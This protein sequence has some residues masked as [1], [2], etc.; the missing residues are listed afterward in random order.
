MLLQMRAQ[1]FDAH[2]VDPWRALVALNSRQRFLQIVPLDNRFHAR[3]GQDRRAFDRDVRR[4]GFGPSAGAAS[5]FTR[6]RLAESQFKLDFRPLSQC[7]NSGLLA[8]STVRAFGRRHA[9]L[10]YPLLTSAPRSRA[11][12]R[13][14]SSLP[15][16]TRIS[17]GKFGRLPRAPAEFTTPVFD[18][19][20]LR[21]HTPARPAG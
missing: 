3:S 13:A 15:D 8:L 19:C 12:R 18:D 4:I 9:G 16:A 17:R 2:P 21:G 20:G 5:G 6:R 10:I 7:E 1:G 11:L 14:Q